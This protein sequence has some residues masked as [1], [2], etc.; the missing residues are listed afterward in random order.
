MAKEREYKLFLNHHRL[1]FVAALVC[2]IRPLSCL[3]AEDPNRPQVIIGVLEYYH[4]K[5]AEEPPNIISNKNPTY[6]RQVRVLFKKVA[7]RW[8]AFEHNVQN[9]KELSESIRLYPEYVNWF[10]AFDGKTLSQFKSFRPQDVTSYSDIGLHVPDQNANLPVIG[11]LSREFSGWET[12]PALRP[13]VLVS[14][15]HTSDPDH[16]KPVRSLDSRITRLC[17]SEFRK[18][19]PT[20]NVSTDEEHEIMKTYKDNVILVNKSY[21]SSN[22]EYI[23]AISIDPSFQHVNGMAKEEWP[24]DWF[25]VDKEK[26][27]HALG[28]GMRLV[29]AGDYDN[30]GTSEVVFWESD[31]NKGGYILFYNHFTVKEEFSWNYH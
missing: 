7:N 6:K 23:V 19:R 28:S 2:A 12:E 10:V 3:E 29:D 21:A 31:Y 18:I 9:T 5:S 24:S 26:I 15:N 11:K 20:V 27:A 14:E 30:D 8:E 17:F 16:W 1:F 22:G 25:Y 13:L 4:P